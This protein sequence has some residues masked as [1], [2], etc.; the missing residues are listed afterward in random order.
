MIALSATFV[1]S[2]LVIFILY[3]YFLFPLC[4]SSLSK[5]PNAHFT[6]A[7]SPCWILWQR[8]KEEE[9]HVIHAAH[10]KHGPIVRLGPR[11]ISVNCV[12]G[13]LRTIYT[14]NFEKPGW[15][16]MFINYESVIRVCDG[17]MTA[18]LEIVCEICFPRWIISRILCRN[19][20]YQMSIRNLTFTLPRT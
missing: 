19:G 4:L 9:I 15:Y 6:S 1:L 5:I 11:D 20:K 13:G 2:F 18:H 16:N 10:Q 17:E 14:G 8:F 3:K 12:D 7:F